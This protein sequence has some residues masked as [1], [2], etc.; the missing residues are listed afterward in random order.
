ML[1]FLGLAEWFDPSGGMF[2]WMKVPHVKDTFKLISEKARA[3]EVLFVP[4]NAFMVDSS[5]PC[6]YLRASYSLVST[7]QMDMVC[8]RNNLVIYILLFSVMLS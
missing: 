6:Q 2:L 4:G 7:E 8:L 3:K 1:S 5:H